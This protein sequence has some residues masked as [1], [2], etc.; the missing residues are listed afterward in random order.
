MST[1]PQQTLLLFSAGISSPGVWTPPG[2][3]FEYTW[4]RKVQ[5]MRRL[6]QLAFRLGH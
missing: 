3:F 4:D 1:T 5:P 6:N 2:S